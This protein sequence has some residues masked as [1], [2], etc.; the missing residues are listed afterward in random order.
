MGLT[1]REMLTTLI[2]G[3]HPGLMRHVSAKPQQ[4]QWHIMASSK[5]GAVIVRPNCTVRPSEDWQWQSN[6]GKPSGLCQI[7]ASDE[8]SFLPPCWRRRVIA[9]WLWVIGETPWL[10]RPH[11]DLSIGLAWGGHVRPMYW[12]VCGGGELVADLTGETRG[13]S[14]TAKVISHCSC[15]PEIMW[16]TAIITFDWK[17]RD[18]FFCGAY[19]ACII[20]NWLQLGESE[21]QAFVSKHSRSLAGHK[22]FKT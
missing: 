12:D 19:N 18:V 16:F 9:S 13:K 21:R 15:Q 17:A 11:T 2:N 7:S 1:L 5:R 3:P 20:Y 6:Y 8:F 10:A 4:H 22:T 14:F